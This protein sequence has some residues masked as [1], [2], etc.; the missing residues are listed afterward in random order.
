MSI[1]II[2]YT[3]NRLKAEIKAGCWKQIE[4]SGLPITVND[5][6]VGEVGA[7]SMFRQIFDCLERAKETYVFFCEHDILYHPSH[8]KFVPPR[9]DTFYYNV[10]VW[11]WN[12]YSDRVITYDHHASVSGL[13]VNRELAREFYERR[14]SIILS[15]GYDKL[16]TFGNPVWARSM[17]Y[18]PGKFNKEGE[19][20]KKEEWRSEFPN[21]DI[22]HTRTM[23]A[24]KIDYEDFVRKPVNWQE[25]TIDKLPGWNKPWML[26]RQ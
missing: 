2:Y 15:K 22:R 12:Y 13:C 14:I 23:T 17:G 11:R 21:I 18:E 6:V 26:V 5:K 25:S 19:S 10:N 8:F 24:P 7:M 3:S 4:Q 20:A 9:D 1:G 16:P